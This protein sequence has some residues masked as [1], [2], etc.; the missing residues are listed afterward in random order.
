MMS[1]PEGS[2]A[3]KEPTATNTGLLEEGPAEASVPSTPQEPVKPVVPPA[4]EAQDD[5][6]GIQ[7][8]LAVPAPAP[9]ALEAEEDD[10]E[11]DSA[12]GESIAS[13]TTS[14]NSSI[15]KYREENGRTYH[16]Y[17]VSPL[18]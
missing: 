18:N 16:A 11:N 15:M 4:S 9:A 3:S 17:K 12:V 7:A 1:K 2:K 6:S 10:W 14:L 5:Q 8:P 13:S